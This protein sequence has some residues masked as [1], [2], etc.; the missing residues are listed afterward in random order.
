MILH[1]FHCAKEGHTRIAIRTV[2][3]DV[4]VLATAYVPK[5]EEAVGHSIELWLAFGSGG[6]IRYIPCHDISFSLGPEKSM[7]LPFLHALTGCD[8]TSAFLGKGKKSAW[9]AW[10][11]CPSVTNSF[12]ELLSHPQD[13]N[14]NVLADIERFVVI[15]YSRTCPEIRINSARKYLFAKGTN[16][17]DKIP[18]TRAALY[19]HIRR[20]CYQASFVWGQ[21]LIP[22]PVYPDPKDWGWHRDDLQDNWRPFWSSLPDASKACKELIRCGC[23]PNKG[24]RGLCKC[25]R[26]NLACTDLCACQGG[27]TN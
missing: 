24:C 23:N 21:C 18:P 27:C 26:S 15:L 8:T 20:V 14:E 7:A 6:K 11:V 9:E 5:I 22:N 19:Q 13:E 2:D 16:K 17:L 25:C 10:K 3:T 12:Q 1:V 4:A